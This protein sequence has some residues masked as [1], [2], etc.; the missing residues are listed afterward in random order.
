MLNTA[1]KYHAEAHL[2]H[3]DVIREV[4]LA[5]GH[6]QVATDVLDVKL[7]FLPLILINQTVVQQFL[8]KLDHLFFSAKCSNL[9]LLNFD[10]PSLFTAAIQ[11]ENHNQRVT[12]GC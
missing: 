11:T 9:S 5:L 4:H 7:G 3:I 1:I 10:D 12:L 6:S 8:L 2:A